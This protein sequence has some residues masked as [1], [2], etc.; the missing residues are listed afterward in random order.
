MA[1]I[2]TFPVT[3]EPLTSEPVATPLRSANLMGV[4]AVGAVE[5]YGLGAIINTYD[6]RHF[7]LVADGITDDSAAIAACSSAAPAG[8]VID[9]PQGGTV[10]MR[11][12]V[13]LTVD[14]LT[15]R[16]N[17]CR[18]ISDDTG[19]DR[20]FLVSGRTG[21]KFEGL[22]IDGLALTDLVVDPKPGFDTYTPRTN[23]GT[24]H[25]LN[26]TDCGVV[27]C[28]FDGINFPITILGACDTIRIA[29]NT[30]S[31]YYV[32]VFSYCSTV[33]DTMPGMNNAFYKTPRRVSVIDND[34]LTGKYRS[35][36]F[37]NIYGIYGGRDYDFK[38]LGTSGAVK[39]RGE[40]PVPSHE[41]EKPWNIAVLHN[42]SGN[43]IREAGTMGI[44]LQ[45][46]CNDTTVSLN[47]ISSCGTGISL[48]V[49]GRTIISANTIKDCIYASVE[50]EG[51]LDGSTSLPNN[52]EIVFTNNVMDGR[53]DYGRPVNWVDNIGIIID[54]WCRNIIING[55]IIK[56]H[57]TGVMVKG[58]SDNIKISG[59]KITTNEQSGHG[60]FGPYP[61]GDWS[62]NFVQG[63]LIYHATNVDIDDCSFLPTATAWQRMV[64]L[65]GATGVNVRNCTIEANNTC[66][67]IAAS[68]NIVVEECQ[69]RPGASVDGD[70]SAYIFIDSTSG[71][72]SDIT[73]RDN[74]FTGTTFAN[75][76]SIYIPS[77]SC[78]HL[79]VIDNDTRLAS[80]IN[81]KFLDIGVSGSGTTSD[82]YTAEN[83]GGS[84]ESSSIDLPVFVADLNAP[85]F[86]DRE[87]F[88]T[89]ITQWSGSVFLQ[90]GATAGKRKKIVCSTSASTVSIEPASGET[91]NGSSSPFVLAYQW[92]Q[93]ELVSDG[94]GNWI[95][96]SASPNVSAPLGN[97][98][99]KDSLK[100]D[101]DNHGKRIKQI[102]TA[103]FTHDFGT[104]GA[105]SEVNDSFSVQCNS[106]KTYGP[107]AIFNWDD[108]LAADVFVRQCYVESANVVRIRLKNP[109][110]SSV[111]VGSVSFYITVI[112]YAE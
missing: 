90:P 94:D 53:D 100:I 34:F 50:C 10:L 55:G 58:E 35:F 23:P 1:T 5:Q 66:I 15:I 24:I 54:K 82:I 46:C 112:E 84:S 101:T 22:R 75:G 93:V 4:S 110:G 68:S 69:L 38:D 44:E 83:K 73:I 42:I 40:S 81:S 7:G 56:Y 31:Q 32:G 25:F 91:I 78:D 51:W 102:T 96:T 70:N 27:N 2:T 77:H 16:G 28:R 3:T 76:I 104:I 80:V 59:L 26:S 39:F 108:Y 18:I 71:S 61:T 64:Y 29:L 21:I 19:Q 99:I 95:V 79:L 49:T 8:S 36:V 87:A 30:F 37:E 47:R 97:V 88:S 74:K 107:A 109:T 52:E 72:C 62:D 13:T 103:R 43:T 11:S 20:K 57:R 45:G 106:G 12:Y 98:L 86:T 33:I 92:E 14:H 63:I 67:Y 105:N 85:D 89:V 48:S 9:F 6:L 65:S 60:G 17:G 111:S 41:T